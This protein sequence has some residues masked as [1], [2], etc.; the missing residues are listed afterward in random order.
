MYG[1][2]QPMNVSAPISDSGTDVC[3]DVS[4]SASV[5]NHQNIGYDAHPLDNGIGVEG[6][7]T[8]PMYATAAVASASD[9]AIVQR[10]D[11]ASQL[12]LSFRGQVYV[13]DEITPDKF[14]A[15][16]LL[17]GG[18]ELTSGPHGVEMSSQNLRGGLDFPRSN[19]PHRA[20]SL[21][22]FRQ[23][24]KERCF[25][26]KVR[27]GVRQEVALSEVVLSEWATTIGCT[28]GAFPTEYLGLPLGAKNSA[29]LWDP[30]IH[31][32]YKKLAGWKNA[33]LSIA[34]RA[35]MDW[36]GSSSGGI[37]R[38][39]V[40][41]DLWICFLR[42]WNVSFAVPESPAALISTWFDLVPRSTIWGF[43]PWAILWS[44]WKLRN[45]IVFNKGKVDYALLSFLTRYRVAAWFYSKYSK[46]SIPFD[47][48]V[49][50]LT[51]ADCLP[52]Y[53]E[54]PSE[55][56]VGL[57]PPIL[58]KLLAI[59]RG[60]LLLLESGR[61]ANWRRILESDCSVALDWI[62]NPGAST[63]LF[64]SVVKDIAS[65]VVDRGVIVRH[66]KR[67]AN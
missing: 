27:Y 40:S 11:D 62:K 41:W 65:I 12:T 18:C 15:V 10:A 17:L 20:A 46:V 14:H 6:V 32:F 26:K 59:K 30:V 36:G 38:L 3:D 1:Q 56:S 21:D 13:F 57:D 7:A 19:Q 60:L 2:S 64:E 63:L 16:L 31:K 50:D 67:V 4:A 42:L 9:L 34:G 5:D 61:S 29:F 49:G 51:L 43:I 25:V 66:V 58:A 52:S 23:K 28:M 39:T 8:D 22:R 54:V 35:C 33:S 24:R 47:S 48:L 45:E 44:I 37:V 53:K 55:Y